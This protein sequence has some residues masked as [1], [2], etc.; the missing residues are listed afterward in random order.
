MDHRCAILRAEQNVKANPNSREEYT[1]RILLAYCKTPGTTGSIRRPD[2]LLASQLYERGVPLV[3][4]DNALLLGAARRLF[5]DTNGP[6]LAPVRSL[7]YFLPVIEEVLNLHVSQ[8]YFD[9]LRRK[10]QRFTRLQTAPL[11]GS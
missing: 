6:P 5:R 8:D 9:H 1:H 10:I 7:A 4:V 2:R 3:A 11:S